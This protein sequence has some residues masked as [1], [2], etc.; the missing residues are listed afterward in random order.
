[1]D[2]DAICPCPPQEEG[3]SGTYLA[4]K[5]SQHLGT[6]PAILPPAGLPLT[7]TPLRHTEVRVLAEPSNNSKKS[8]WGQRFPILG[9]VFFE[10]PRR[11][12][13][14]LRHSVDAQD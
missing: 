12:A 2:A 3:T 10:K 1:M 13:S 8:G 11:D 4:G 5:P 14:I 6:N 9:R 7:L